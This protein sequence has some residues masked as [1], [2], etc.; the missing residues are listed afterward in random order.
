MV[1]WSAIGCLYVSLFCSSVYLGHCLA[2]GTRWVVA[3]IAGSTGFAALAFGLALPRRIRWTDLRE[4]G[5]V[6]LPVAV[7]AAIPFGL[8]DDMAISFVVAPLLVAPIILAHRQGLVTYD[9]TG[10]SFVLSRMTA[11][12]T[13]RTLTKVLYETGY[14]DMRYVRMIPFTL[15]TLES[16][17]MVLLWR[18]RRAYDFTLK[19]WSFA[20]YIVLKT[21]LLLGLPRIEEALDF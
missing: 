4:T 1:G 21:A 12:T 2:G 9:P 11:Y 16:L 6:W 17:G 18:T 7:S 20:T 14:L 15:G 10:A 3:S 5:I 19:S 8:V 13:L